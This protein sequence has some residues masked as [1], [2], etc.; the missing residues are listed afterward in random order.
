MWIIVGIVE[1][2]LP[3]DPAVVEQLAHQVAQGRL[4]RAGRPTYSN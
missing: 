4:A 3:E 1:V 2:V